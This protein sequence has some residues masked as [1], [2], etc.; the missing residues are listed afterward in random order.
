MKQELL[1]LGVDTK[2]QGRVEYGFS[3]SDRYAPAITVFLSPSSATEALSLNSDTAD[4]VLAAVKKLDALGRLHKGWDSYGGLPISAE[5]RRVTF[6]ALE[7]LKCRPLPIPQVVLGSNGDVSLEWRAKGRELELGFGESGKVGYVKVDPQGEIEE[8][9]EE[10]EV[11]TKLASLTSW[12][13][14]G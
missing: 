10:K 4:W 14:G 3:L 8:G 13:T 7:W 6:D 2:Y 1:D 12:L 5:A 11:R 9:E